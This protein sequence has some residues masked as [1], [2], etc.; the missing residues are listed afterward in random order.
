MRS[1]KP[2]RHTHPVKPLTAIVLAL[3]AGTLLVA[4]F[5]RFD[6]YPL[7]WLAFVPLF[8]A[9]EGRKPTQAFLLGGFFGLVYFFGTLSWVTLSMRNYGGLSPWLSFTAMFLLVAYLSVYV[10]FFTA[11]L[12]ACARLTEGGLL[13]FTPALWVVLE[14]AKG[15][16]FTGFPWASLAYSQTPFLSIIQIADFGGIYVVGFVMMLVNRAFYLSLRPCFHGTFRWRALSWKPLG[17]AGAFFLLTLGYGLFRLSEPVNHGRS[18]RVAVIQ[19]NIAQD[20]KWDRAFQEETLNIYERLSLSTLND[21]EKPNLLLWPEAVLPFVFGSEPGHERR[22][23][24]F[25]DEQNIPL[26]LGAPSMRREDTE[27]LTL[28]NSAFYFSPET[29]QIGRYDKLH[30]VPFGEYVPLPKLLFFIGKLVEGV[31]DFLPGETATVFDLGKTRVAAV[32]CFE[33]IFPEV[34][35][36]FVQ[37]GAVIMTTLT[38]DAWFGTSSAPFQHFSMVQFRAIENR[39]PFARAANTGISGFIDAK[40]RVLQT[41]PLF[42]EATATETLF[43]RTQTT[44]Y[45]QWG[46]FFAALCAI[47]TAIILVIEFFNRRKHDAL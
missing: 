13:F 47:I 14:W 3:S 10:G 25:V 31:G 12:Q 6:L 15:H 1:A 40:G 37:N 17:V 45:T 19:G 18:L 11:L 27:K 5:P 28:R 9:I 44:L 33:V 35:R 36:Q 2:L 30:L 42:V 8:F 24:H 23:R 41:S 46:D 29:E 32:I 21:E 34:V 39:I 16:F 38:N 20:Q 43:R 22:L 7:A 26:I 4:S